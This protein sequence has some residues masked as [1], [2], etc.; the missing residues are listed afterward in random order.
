MSLPKSAQIFTT[1][2]HGTVGV[3]NRI[4]QALDL[5]PCDGKNWCL[6]SPLHRD[7]ATLLSASSSTTGW[8]SWT[9]LLPSPGPPALFIPADFAPHTCPS[10]GTEQEG[11]DSPGCEKETL[12]MNLE[13]G[14]CT[15]HEAVAGW[16]P[17]PDGARPAQG[18]KQAFQLQINFSLT[19][20]KLV[21]F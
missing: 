9:I 2:P 17:D 12:E 19:P 11:Q 16:S 15:W 3:S 13:W 7:T 18:L 1:I 5:A 21:A 6:P 8:V 20:S 10:S 14:S 4:R